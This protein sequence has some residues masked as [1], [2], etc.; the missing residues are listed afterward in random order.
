MGRESVRP[1]TIPADRAAQVKRRIAAAR[2]GSDAALGELLQSCR[3]YLLMVANRCFP[4]DLRAKAGASDIVSETVMAALEDFRTFDG[5]TEGQLLGWLCAILRHKIIIFKERF[6]TGKR[7]ATREKP[8]DAAISNGGL[9]ELLTAVGPSPSSQVIEG[10]DR[11]AFYSA[12]ERLPDRYL[13]VF[14]LHYFEQLTFEEVG[15]RL[16]C[17]AEAAR[18]VWDRAVERLSQELKA[19]HG[20]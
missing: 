17:S 8:I 5:D 13:Q 9:A 16:Y 15:R 18:K 20:D 12:L 14:L 1:A 4:D 10:E 2:D 3:Q 7:D 19:S 11:Q 6:H